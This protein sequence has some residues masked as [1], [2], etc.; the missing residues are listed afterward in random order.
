M[1]IVAI[2]ILVVA[3]RLPLL[4][5]D[6]EQLFKHHCVSCHRKLPVNHQDIFKRYVLNFSAKKY[7]KAALIHY[8]KYPHK[9]ISVMSKLFLDTYGVKRPTI[10][11]DEELKKVIDYYWE[12][13]TFL[14]RLQ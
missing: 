4:A 1:R 14:G 8:L 3:L 11:T 10:L 2:A 5:G 13:Y 6:G 12:R 9:D 7:V